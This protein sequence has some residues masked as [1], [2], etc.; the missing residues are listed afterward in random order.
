MEKDCISASSTVVITGIPP[1]SARVT[2]VLILIGVGGGG[3]ELDTVGCFIPPWIRHRC[4]S[5]KDYSLLP[6]VSHSSVDR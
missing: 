1:H 2:R 5:L 4:C 6:R 3:G